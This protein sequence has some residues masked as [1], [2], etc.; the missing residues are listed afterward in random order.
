MIRALP[1]LMSV[2][3]LS[4][5]LL[6]ACST[7]N[8][9]A[10][11]A[12]PAARQAETDLNEIR[13]TNGIWPPYNG[14]DLPNFGCDSQVVQ[15]S[16]ALMGV[17]VHYDFFPWVR[18]YRLSASGEWDGTISWADTPDHRAEHYISEVPTSTQEFVFFYRKD[19][20]FDWETVNDLAGKTL[21]VTAGYVY[22]D[23]FK[24]L[25]AERKATFIESSSDEANFKMLLAGR[26]DVFPM[27]RRVG[28]YLLRSLFTP[29]EQA[30]L[31]DSPK[32][33]TQFRPYLLLSRAN[34][35]NEERM[36]LFDLGFKRLQAIG[37]YVQIMQACPR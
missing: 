4:V 10:P 27:E 5:V 33:F 19:H 22:S 12:P 7:L 11:T 1:Q 24:E 17:T 8:P 20:P 14:P 36:K 2:M 15:E 32:S 3:V 30:Q 37:R 13:L 25:R 26:I 28:R 23:A 6:S 16:F 9:P 21:G 29:A 35:Q 34:P 31:T 18:S